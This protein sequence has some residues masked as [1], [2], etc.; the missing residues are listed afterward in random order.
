M[1]L[2]QRL[3]E[4][5]PVSFKVARASSGGLACR[6]N[7]DFYDFARELPCFRSGR[8]VSPTSGDC[9]VVVDRQVAP[10]EYADPDVRQATGQVLEHAISIDY[11]VMYPGETGLAC[12]KLIPTDFWIFCSQ[13]KQAAAQGQ[14]NSYGDR[15]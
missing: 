14:D 3:Y 11:L 12:T 10:A 13:L 2:R 9:R 6:T 5:D 8:R 4:T 1:E 7:R 15:P